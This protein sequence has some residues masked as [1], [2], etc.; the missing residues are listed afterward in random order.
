MTD[1][2]KAA[3][4]PWHLDPDPDAHDQFILSADGTMVA[5]CA[6]LNDVTVAEANTALIVK[7]INERDG[8][9]AALRGLLD[10]VDAMARRPRDGGGVFP[11]D[12]GIAKANARAVLAKAAG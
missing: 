10:M 6:L 8:L 12:Y 4:R 9:V 1:P 5:D 11:A 2:S 3:P 7:A